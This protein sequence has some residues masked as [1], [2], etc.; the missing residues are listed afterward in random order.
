MN[1]ARNRM[2]AAALFAVAAIPFF[3]LGN[4][5]LAAIFV[6]LAAVFLVMG[7]LKAF[8]NGRGGKPMTGDER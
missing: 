4:A 3:I 1:A 8:A 7:P 5:T 2:L 6:V